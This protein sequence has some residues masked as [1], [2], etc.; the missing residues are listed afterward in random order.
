MQHF[1]IPLAT[2][3]AWE[4]IPPRAVRMPLAR[5]IPSR[6]SGEVSIRVR[7]VY[8]YLAASSAKKTICPVAAPG[9][10]GSPWA[11]TSAFF[12]AVGS[13][14]G[15]RSSSSLLGVILR[16]ASLSSISPS[17]IKSMAIFTMAAPVRFPFLVCRIQSFPC[18]MVNSIS[19]ISL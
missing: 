10:A 6:S 7:M 16:R 11:M 15:C 17:F 13:K 9:E 14:T 2:T 1:P 3:A 12:R 18:C 19:C 5:F 4:V 8:L